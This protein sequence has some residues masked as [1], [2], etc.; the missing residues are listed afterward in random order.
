LSNEENVVPLSDKQRAV[1]EYLYQNYQSAQVEMT[2]KVNE[3]NNYL[4][5]VGNELK[6]DTNKYQFDTDNVVF[7][8]IE[9]VAE[10]ISK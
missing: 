8:P 4:V 7:R 5:K 3:L 2:N 9:K 10:D 6:I 1:F